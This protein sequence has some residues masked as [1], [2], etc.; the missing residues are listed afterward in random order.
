MLFCCIAGAKVNG[1]V[2]L[3]SNVNGLQDAGEPGLA[4][5]SVELRQGGVVVATTM[6]NSSGDFSFDNVAPGTYTVL[7]QRPN[8]Y[9][10]SPALQ[11]TDRTLDSDVTNLSS[12]ET[13]PFTL[14]AGQVINDVDAGL[15][16]GVCACTLWA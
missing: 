1:V 5:I 11:G 3:D 16:H 7:V 8:G 14:S 9:S 10:F 15:Y 6:T 2:W 12:G 13:S 4:G